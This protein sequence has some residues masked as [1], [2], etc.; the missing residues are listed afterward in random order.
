MG[1]S[2]VDEAHGVL[3]G[4]SGA[5]DASESGRWEALSCRG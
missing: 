5:F 1:H 4:V 2:T 3:N